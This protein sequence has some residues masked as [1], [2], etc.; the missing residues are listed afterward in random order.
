MPAFAW[1]PS[2]TSRMLKLFI[3]HGSISL[4]SL[5]LLEEVG[6]SYEA[7]CVDF[8]CNEQQQ[9]AYLKI[10]SNGRAPSFATEHGTLTETRATLVYIAQRFGPNHLVTISSPF[11]FF[12]IQDFHLSFA[13]LLLLSHSPLFL[14]LLSL[15]LH[16]SL[17]PMSLLSPETIPLFVNFF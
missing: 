16:P 10:H 14:G 17:A 2:G 4:A 12:L 11:L 13:S 15:L 9:D 8:S 6:A 3:A 7:V 1:R 5:I